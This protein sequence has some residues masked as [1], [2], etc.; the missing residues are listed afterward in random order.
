MDQLHLTVLDARII[1]A[2]LIFHWTPTLCWMKTTPI[3]DDE[4]LELIRSHPGKDAVE[5]GP[6]PDDRTA[7]H[8]ASTEALRASKPTSPSAMTSIRQRTILEVM[9]LDRPGLLARIGRIFME[10]GVNPAKRPYC[11]PGRARGRRILHYRPQATTDFRF[12]Y[13][14]STG[15]RTCAQLDQLN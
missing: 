10:H 4:R 13:L 3:H 2:A 5:P 12:G 9:T 6:V 14:Q 8:A 15:R 1:T 7:T 11:H